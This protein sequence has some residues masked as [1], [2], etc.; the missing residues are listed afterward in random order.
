MT[1]PTAPV[2]ES[3]R[4]MEKQVTFGTRLGSMSLYLNL[5]NIL[6]DVMAGFTTGKKSE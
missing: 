5:K 3:E 1:R 2:S 6:D 4:I